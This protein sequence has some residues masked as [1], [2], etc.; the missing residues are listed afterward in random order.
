MNAYPLMALI[1]SVALLFGFFNAKVLKLQTSIAMMLSAMVIAILLLILQW[2][3]IS[4][5]T[6]ACR[7][8]IQHLNFSDLLLNCLLSFLL[9]AGALTLN[10]DSL[11]KQKWAIGLLALFSTLA[12]TA[13]VAISTHYLLQL[14][15]VNFPWIYAWL[16]G[17]LISPTDPIAVLATF[18]TMGAP[19]FLE[20]AVA[21]ESLFNDGI[22][23][24]I[25]I[26]LLEVLTEGTAPH[27]AGIVELFFQEAIGGLVYGA[28]IGATALWL[29]RQTTDGKL[30]LLTTLVVVSGG[31][32]LALW[33]NLSGPLA[34]VVAGIWIG[35][36]LRHSHHYHLLETVWEAIDEVMNTVLFLLIGFELLDFS[37][38]AHMLWTA[39]LAIPLVLVIRWITVAA[40]LSAL[41]KALKKPKMAVLL[42]WGGLRGGLAIAL[43]LSLPS[44]AARGIILTLTY[45]VVAFSVIIQGVTVRPLIRKYYPITDQ[46]IP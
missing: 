5:L 34:M 15:G 17:A 32:T 21:G 28:L 20:A 45:G 31:Y 24:V 12:S 8:I 1:L 14:F 18:K 29:C 11:R 30:V 16:F 6:E 9:F 23:I 25:F 41:P 44:S 37:V 2:M 38:P 42:T 4:E 40:P 19:R 13:L 43:A 35:Q 26:T 10:F 33:L 27:V 36:G 7:K 3:H 22:G 39:F 46:V